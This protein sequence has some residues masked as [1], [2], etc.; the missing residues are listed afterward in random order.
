MYDPNSRENIMAEIYQCH[1]EPRMRGAI[2]NLIMQIIKYPRYKSIPKHFIKT[3]NSNTIMMIS[4]PMNVLFS[5]KNFSIPLQIYIMKNCPNEAP[6]FFLEVGPNSAPNPKNKDI[7]QITNQVMTYSLRNW[8]QFSNIDNVM[9]EIYSSFSQNFPLYKK[10]SQNNQSFQPPQVIPPMVIPPSV[11]PSIPPPVPPPSNIYNVLNSAVQ[12]SYNQYGQY[13]Y[14]PPGGYYGTGTSIYGQP[15]Q[16]VPPPSYPNQGPYGY[17]SQSQIYSQPN[18]PKNPEVS[19]DPDKDFEK[20]IFK[21][22]NDKISSK[23]LEEN[24]RLENQN[25]KLIEFR[26][27]INEENNK[28]QKFIFDEYTIKSNC[29]SDIKNIDN[30]LKNV[31]EYN[32]K[33]KN[34][35]INEENCLTYIN[36][37]DPTAIKIIANEASEEELILVIKKAFEKKKISFE[38][39]LRFTRNSTK[40]LFALKYMK[41]KVIKKYQI[42]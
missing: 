22:V 38:E 32:E 31:K 29:E 23:L 9:N 11:P 2:A 39:A 30:V 24:K 3:V 42:F 36:I 19:K 13:P 4:Y 41:N 37:S 27:E 35:S 14:P 17:D 6:Q 40:E 1:Y 33:N 5:N 25:K 12:L 15:M 10:K 16:P 8:G 28:L 21:E 7:N 20:I 18:K 34:K 26:K